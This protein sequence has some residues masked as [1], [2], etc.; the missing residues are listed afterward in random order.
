MYIRITYVPNES[1]GSCQSSR[2]QLAE[3]KNSKGKDPCRVATRHVAVK[4]GY[5]KTDDSKNKSGAVD[6]KTT[7]PRTNERPDWRKVKCVGK[8]FKK[9]WPKEWIRDQVLGKWNVWKR[10]PKLM[11]GPSED[12]K[13]PTRREIYFGH[14]LRLKKDELPRRTNKTTTT[15]THIPRDEVQNWKDDI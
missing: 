15:T 2:H 1:D 6:S 10:V 8:E 5:S 3:G 11:Q 13:L 7:I 4:R 12:S 9:L 14:I